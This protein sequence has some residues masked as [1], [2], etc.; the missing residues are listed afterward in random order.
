MTN[1][2]PVRMVNFVGRDAHH[3]HAFSAFNLRRRGAEAPSAAGACGK[4]HCPLLLQGLEWGDKK[5][6][7]GEPSRPWSCNC[8]SLSGQ[9]TGLHHPVSLTFQHGDGDWHRQRCSVD[10]RCSDTCEARAHHCCW[11]RDHQ[12]LRHLERGLMFLI[13]LNYTHCRSSPFLYT[14]HSSQVML[15]GRQRAERLPCFLTRY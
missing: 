3:Q 10:D 6:G 14:L 11:S 7:K 13:A 15:W 12:G 2:I 5:A 8:C 1:G 9:R 4:D